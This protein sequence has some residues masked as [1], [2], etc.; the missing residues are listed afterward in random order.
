MDRKINVLLVSGHVAAEHYYPK[1]NEKFRVALEATGKFNVKI[2]EEFNGCTAE[3]LKNY[4][5]IF[6]NYDGK[7]EPKPEVG[8]DYDYIRWNPETEK[9][10]F[11]FVKSGKGV[12]IHHTS[13]F[14][15]DNLPEEYFKMWG[16]YVQLS[17]GSRKNPGNEFR[18]KFEDDTPFARDLYKE[19]YII[20]ED[21]F[22]NVIFRPGANVHVVASAF[23]DLEYY[24]RDKGFPPKRLATTLIPDGKLENMPG[25]NTYQ[26]VAWTNTYGDGRV[27]AMSIGHD[28][29]TW[30]KSTYLTLM[31]RGVEWAATGE[32]T[33]D[34]PDR[35]EVNRF[36]PWPYFGQQPSKLC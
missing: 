12:Y 17:K 33:I 13:T 1:D 32:I 7:D 18:V 31:V 10:F 26:P 22:S 14:L 29:E 35:A 34:P 30:G 20:N 19:W 11:D 27:F 4:D 24:K 28:M 21:L 8:Y 23:D 9:V 3:T 36:K 16:A 5:V 2:T 25:V 15:Q 6:L